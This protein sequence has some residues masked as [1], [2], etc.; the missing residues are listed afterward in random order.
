MDGARDIL[1]REWMREHL[2][3]LRRVARAFAPPADQPDLMQELMLAV[4]R[5]LPAFRGD[6]RPATFIYRVAHNRALTWQSGQGGRARRDAEA[7]AEALRRMALAADPQEVLVLD[8]LYAAIR[9]LPALDRSILILSLDGVPYRDIA[10]MHDMTE[11]NVGVRL[12]RAKGRL[13]GIMSQIE[14]EEEG[15]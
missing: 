2:D 12:T 15:K 5:A 7:A 8:R 14:A 3:L 13:T 10:Q 1:F 9:Q 11:S 6:S 4:W